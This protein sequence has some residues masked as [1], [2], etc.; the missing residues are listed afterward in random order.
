MHRAYGGAT[1]LDLREWYSLERHAR[2]QVASAALSPL[3][4]AALR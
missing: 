2:A 3:R 4:A 1:C